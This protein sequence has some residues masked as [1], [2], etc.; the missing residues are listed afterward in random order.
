MHFFLNGMEIDEQN[1]DIIEINTGLDSLL[2][3]YGV[4]IN[5]DFVIDKN[6]YR[7]TNFRRVEGGI[8]PETVEVPFFIN[9]VDFNE[10]NLAV[11]FQKGLSIVGASSLDTSFSIPPGVKEEILF[12]ST[13]KAGKVSGDLKVKLQAL[14]DADYNTPNIPLGVV[15]SGPFTSYFANRPV[16]EF[17]TMD[18]IM[19]SN[20][21]AKMTEGVDTRIMIVGNGNM[22]DDAA[23]QDRSGRFK[24]NFLFFRNVVDWMSQDE[25]LISIRSKGILYNPFD[26]PVEDS[27]KNTIR[28]INVF[29]IPVLIII[30]GIVRWQVRKS[31]RRRV[32]L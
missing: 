31:A 21:P 10:E 7:Y 1:S 4:G 22:F 2:N 25:D 24:L 12:T 23:A 3:H 14:S 16:P 28:I 15:L 11:K 9:I 5:K 27:Q 20:I 8:I 18:S 13:E 17:N 32:M 26:K 6:C 29:T 30:F 19:A